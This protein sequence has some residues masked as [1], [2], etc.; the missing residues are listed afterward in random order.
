MSAS[1]TCRPTGATP[2]IA[3][4]GSTKGL[5]SRRPAVPAPVVAF[6]FGVAAGAEKPQVRSERATEALAPPEDPT[7]TEAPR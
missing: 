5:L 6:P 2:A 7:P 3:R 1:T 4:R